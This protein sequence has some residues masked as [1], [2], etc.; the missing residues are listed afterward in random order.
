MNWLVERAIA[1]KEELILMITFFFFFSSWWSQHPSFKE[2][3]WLNS[4]LDFIEICDSYP[5]VVKCLISN[6]NTNHHGEV[7]VRNWYLLSHHTLPLS[8]PRQAMVLGWSLASL[9]LW[10]DRERV[11]SYKSA[12]KFLT[13][14]DERC[15][16]TDYTLHATPCW[17]WTAPVFFRQFA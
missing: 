12:I 8:P 9:M 10:N 4:Q 15:Y 14:K 16:F 6:H 5:Y 1:A 11:G 13:E 7:L 2:A 3:N 17:E